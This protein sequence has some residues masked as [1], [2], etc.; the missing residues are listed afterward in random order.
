MSDEG[1]SPPQVEAW[2]RVPPGVADAMPAGSPLRPI[3]TVA[4]HG[5]S[6]GFRQDDVRA[7]AGSAPSQLVGGPGQ[8]D[9]TEWEADRL[10]AAADNIERHAS[11]LRRLAVDMEEIK[12]LLGGEAALASP[13]GALGGF[14]KGLSLAA[15][16]NALHRTTSE[17]LT[18]LSDDMYRA[19]DALREVKRKYDTAEYANKMSAQEMQ[20]ALKAGGPSAGASAEGV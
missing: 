5:P 2:M 6:V 10:E 4:A 20:R 19:A 14:P 12:D 17:S 11:Y 18:K 8:R 7:G 1:N 13:G 16:H 15:A 9:V 3:A